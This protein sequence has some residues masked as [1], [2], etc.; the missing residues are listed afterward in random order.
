MFY[1]VGGYVADNSSKFQMESDHVGSIYQLMWERMME[2][3]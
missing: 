2:S 3:K 1:F